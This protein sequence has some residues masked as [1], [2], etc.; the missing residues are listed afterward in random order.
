MFIFSFA[1]FVAGKIESIIF[2]KTKM[3]LQVVKTSIICTKTVETYPMRT[4]TDV[5]AYKKGHIG[6]NTY[7]LYYKIMI[8][9]SNEVPLKLTDT[10]LEE[11][12]IKQTCLIK[13]FLGMPCSYDDIE[14]IDESTR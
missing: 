2:D 1:F 9:F 7:T 10:A 13:N 6:L 11:K 14:L 5:K 3:E 8:L 12:C 4:I